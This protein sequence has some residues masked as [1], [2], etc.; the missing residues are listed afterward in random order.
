MRLNRRGLFAGVALAA[1][2]F[3]GVP[4][5]AQDY[6]NK[7][8]TF[9]IPYGPGGG[10]DISGRALAAELERILG[11]P[12]VVENVEG[13]GGAVGL[14]QLFNTAPDG[15]TIGVGTGS[16]TTIAPHAVEVGYDP[17]A[18]SYIAGYFG[19]TYMVLVN[20]SVPAT[21]MQ[22]L[23]DWAKANPGALISSTSGGYGIHDVAA[24]LFSEAAG[25]IEYRTLPNNSAAETTQRILAGDANLTF[26]SPATNLEHV[27]AGNMRALAIISDV[28][29]PALDELGIEMTE[30]VLDF[31]LINRTVVLA[32][33]GLPQDIRARLEAAVAQ[34]MES[35]A[36]QQQLVDLSFTPNFKT[37][38]DALAETTEIFNIYGEIITRLMEQ[39][40]PVQ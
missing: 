2:M 25:G 29:V 15:Y 9:I 16:N 24:A 27:K 12:V 20:P 4:A 37:G 18:F 3:A 5:M 1:A 34:A 11:Q 38:P 8:I 30:D 26:G 23:V 28:S 13:G 10:T 7:P 39:G 21:N 17:L 22:E 31:S 35:E 40:G 33:P 14:T 36:I 32:P 6:P 19:W